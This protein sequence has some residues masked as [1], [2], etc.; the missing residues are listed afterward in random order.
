MGENK[1][2][3]GFG[4]ETFEVFAVPGRK[5]RGE[6]AWVG[7]EGRRSVETHAEAIAVYGAAG[8][9]GRGGGVLVSYLGLSYLL[10]YSFFFR[11]YGVSSLV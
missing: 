11:I 8:I 1:G 5:G 3:S 10:T 6:D 7:A 4:S 2:G 9:L